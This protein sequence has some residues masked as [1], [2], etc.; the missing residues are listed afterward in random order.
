[1]RFE[2]IRLESFKCYDDA[3]LRLD[4]G[5]TVIHGLNGSGKSSLLESAFFALYGARAIAK[6]LDDVVTIGAESATVELWFTHDGA[7]YHVE[8]RLSVR[9]DRAVTTKCVLDTP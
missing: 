3:D 9:D 6:T 5:V 4:D 7:S 1:M 8:R 2:R